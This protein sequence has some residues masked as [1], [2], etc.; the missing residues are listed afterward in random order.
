MV[1]DS[2]DERD[3]I[4]L[5]DRVRTTVQNHNFWYD[6]QRLRLTITIGVAYRRRG[7]GV[8]EWINRADQRLYQGKREGK[9]R[10]VA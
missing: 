9:N 2:K 3:P 10:V 4:Q 6:E 7:E 5:L 1:G 8:N